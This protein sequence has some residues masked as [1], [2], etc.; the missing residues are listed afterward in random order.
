MIFNFW[1]VFIFTGKSILSY[2]TSFIYF[3]YF[4]IRSGW[5]LGGNKK[6]KWHHLK[7]SLSFLFSI[8]IVAFLFFIFSGNG[9]HEDPLS[10]LYLVMSIL[11]L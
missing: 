6:A 10:G 11:C 7:H 8:L 9:R 5:F 1:N 2:Y 3:I 4:E